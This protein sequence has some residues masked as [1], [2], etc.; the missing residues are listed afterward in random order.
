MWHAELNLNFKY[1]HHHTVLFKQ[2]KGPLVVQKP[3]YPEGKSVCHVYLLHPPGGLVAG[4]QLTL[5][6]HL[7]AR[8]H[9][10]ITTPGAG[11][12]YKSHLS[13][14]GS[15]HNKIEIED[16]ACLEWFP[17]ETILFDG[18]QCKMQNQIHLHGNAS[19]YTGW[20]ILCLG[21]PASGESFNT[22]QCRQIFEIKRDNQLI[23][24]ERALFE[25]G[26]DLLKARWGL[27][28]YTV[29]GTFVCTL[30]NPDLLSDIRNTIASELT[31][32]NFGI[33]QLK[34]VMVAQYLGHHAEQAKQLFTRL[35]TF[36]R[37][38]LINKPICIPR[39]WHT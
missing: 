10:L 36:I 27:Q 11:K 38:M 21:R 14:V 17:Q 19:Q 5:T 13:R 2:H 30:K 32:C 15:I 1:R 9:A 24:H 12:I 18:A 37:P 25:G 29:F 3:F 26:S 6:A 34:E 4:D 8:S 28:N 35:W 20:E 33:T 22:G 31:E 16:L 39:I 7:Q 23:W